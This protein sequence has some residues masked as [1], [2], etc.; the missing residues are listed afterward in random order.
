MSQIYLDFNASTPVAPEVGRA[1]TAA[2]DAG[3]GNPSSAHWAG[4]PARQLLEHSRAQVATLLGCLQS[5]R[6]RREMLRCEV[7]T[8]THHLRTLPARTVGL[9]VVAEPV[10]PSP[11]PTRCRATRDV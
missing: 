2:L 3:Y 8:S 11:Q 4:S 1:M 6:I 5:V 10:W 7:S 9:T